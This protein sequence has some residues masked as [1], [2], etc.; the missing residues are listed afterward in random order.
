MRKIPIGYSAA[1]IDAVRT[2]TR[3]YLTCGG[4]NTTTID[5][6]AINNYAWCG[7]SSFTASG[8]SELYNDSLDSPVPIFFS[9]TGCTKVG[10]RSFD[11]QVA[12]LGPQMNTKW[13]GAMMYIHTPVKRA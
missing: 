1:D 12:V 13:S 11:D 10:N 4:D 9:E 8:Y 6:F 5:F 3:D 7:P 2:E